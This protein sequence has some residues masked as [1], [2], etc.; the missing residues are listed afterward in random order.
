[1]SQRPRLRFLF[2]AVLLLLVSYPALADVTITGTVLFSSLDG[3]ALDDDHTVNGIFTVNG[4]LTVTGTI[5]CNDV[6]KGSSACPM[7]FVVSGNVTLAPGSQISA[8]NR[9]KDGNGGDISFTVGGN[10][11]IQGTSGA[12]PGA[13]I[14]S[15]KTNGGVVFHAGSI[16]INAGGT[17]TDGAGSIISAASVDGTAGAIS[18]TS[19]AQSSISGNILSGPSRTISTSTIYTGFVMT[20]TGTTVGGNIAIKALTSSEPGVVIN[21][22]AIIASQSG[23]VGTGGTVTIEGC[24][25]Q[26]NGLV[27]SIGRKNPGEHVIVRSGTSITVDGSNLGGAGTHLGRVRADAGSEDASTNTVELYAND[28]IS[29]LGPASSMYAVSSN[30]GAKG[31]GGTINVISKGGTVNATG[32]AFSASGLQKDETGGTINLS[33]KGN[34]TLTGA[35]ITGAGGTSGSNRAGGH[36]NVRSYSGALSWVNGTGDVRPVGSTAGVPTAQQGTISL[37]YCTTLTTTG[38]TF[39]TN[40]SPVGT[41]PTTAQTCSP[42]AP[43]LPA[44][45]TLPVCNTAPVANNDAYTVAEGGTLNV[46]APGVLG[47]DT[48]AEN[49]PLTAVLVTGPAH[50]SSFT[51]NS[52]GSFTYVHDGS[53][54]T[55]DSFT[56]KANDGSLDSNVAT[57]NITITPV[58]DAPVANNDGPYTVAEGGAI[59][60]AAPGV[61]ANDTDPDSPTLTAIL[62]SGPLHAASFGLNANGSW[63]YVHDGSETTSDS[64]TYKANDGS[65]D[66]NVATV[67]IT[68]TPVNDAPVANND[69][70]TVAEGGTLNVAAPGVLGNDTDADSPALT[71]V[72]VTGPAHAS[73]FTLNADGS[74]TYVHDGSETTSDSFTYKA[75]DGSSFSN[76]ATVSITIT[77]V[78]DAP[79]ANN[80]SATVAEG[81]T[82]TVAAPGVLGNDTDPDSPTLT[83]IL[84]S[85]PAHASSFTFNSNGSY[86]YVHDGSETLSDSFTYKAND[87][88]LDSNVATVNITIT[89]VNDAPVANNDSATVA[90]GGT[91]NVAAPGVLGNDT[92]S[93]SPTLTAILVT[94]PAHASSFTLNSNGSYTYVHDGSET[95]SDSFTYKANDGFLDSNV[96]T[97]NITITPVNDAPVANNDAYGVAEGGTL[98]VTAPGVLGNDTDVDSPTLTAV[99]VSSPIHAASFALNADGSF[100]YVHDGSETTTDTF[101]YKA[102]DGSLDSNVATVTIT[103]TAVND[104]P[105]ITAG[106][107]LN[108]TENDPA[109]VVDNTITVSD[110][111]S[112]NLVGATVQI[113]SNYANGQDVLSFATI[114]AISGSFSSAT[115][116]LT[117][118]GTDTVANYQAALRTVKYANTSENPSTAPRT[119]S[120]Q[121][122]DGAGVNNLSNLATSTINV[123]SVNDAPVAA[124][125]A[126]TV[127]EGGTLSIAAPGVLGNDS[128]VDSPSLTAVLV[129][130]P[131]HAASFALNA[132]GSFTYV[133]DGSETT[134]DSFTYKASD[135]SLFSNVATVSITITPVNDA[136]V[137]TAGGTLNYTENDPASVIDN[138]ITIS[139]ADSTTLA[140]ATAQITANYV[141]GQDF[142]AFTNTPNISGSFS[143]ATGTLTLTGTDT[144]ANYQAALRSVTYVNTS[145]APSAAPRTVSWQVN[146]GAGVNNLSNV[147][148]STINVTSVNDAPVLTG[149]TTLA[150]TENQAATAIDTTITVTDADSTNLASATVQITTN[151]VNGQDVLSYANALGITGSFNASTGTLTLSG[152]SSVANYQTALR[153]VKY[154]NTSD[155][156]S[157]S[158]RTVT[159]QVND[160]GAL[161]NLSNIISSTVNVTAV[162]DQPTA[163]AF[164]GLPAQAGIPITYPAGKLGGTDVEAGTTVTIDTAPINLVNVAGVVLNADGSFTFTPTPGSAGGSASFQ[165]RVSDNGNPAPGVNGAYVTVSF[166]V[167]GPAIYFAKSAPVGAGNCTLGNECTVATAVTAIGASTNA[168]IFVSDANTQSVGPITLNSGGSIIGQGVVAASFDAFFGIGT[169]SQGTLAARPLVNQ[170]RPTLATNVTMNTNSQTRGFNLTPPIG[171]GLIATSRTGLVVSDM[172][173][174][175]TT[176]NVAQ[177]CVHFTSSSGTFSFGNITV[178]GTNAGAGINFSGTTSTSTATF[179]NVTTAGGAAVTVATSGSTNFTFGTVTSTTG[180]AVTVT[181]GSGAFTFTKINAGTSVAGPTKGISVNGLTGSFVVNGSGGLCDATHTSGSDCTGGTIQ[182]ASARGAEFINSNNVTLKKMY[183]KSNSTTVA[184]GCVADVS[185]GSNVT[186]NGP[187]FLQTVNGATLDTVFLDGSSQMGLVANGVSALNMSASE[188]RNIGSAFSGQSGLDLQN[189]SGTNVI[190]GC[191]IHD[192]DFGHNVL[193]TNNTGTATVNFTNNTV[194]NVTITTPTSSD[195][196]QLQAYSSANVTATVSN[197]AGTC[198]FN[199]LFSNGIVFGANNASVLNATLSNCGVTKTAGVFLQGSGT[200]NMTGTVSGNTITNKVAS[201]GF[202][203]GSN[204][205]TIGKSSGSSTSTFTGSVTNNTITKAN[206]GGGCTGIVAGAF[207]N[208]TT[209]MT[210]TGNNIQHVDAE[211]INFTAG[212]ASGTSNNVL[213]IQGNTLTN[214]DSSGNYPID[215]TLGTSTGDHP[216]LAANI[217]DMSVGHTVAANRN[218]I[219]NGTFQWVN[220][221]GAP[222]IGPIGNYAP[223]ITGVFKLFNLTGGTDDT[224]AQNWIVASNPG[225]SSDAFNG[226]VAWQSGT[227]CP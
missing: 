72:L 77:P 166:T 11:D 110:A 87:G 189:L 143:S 221:G 161:N 192:N 135:G 81:G 111:D 115:G 60:F 162:N 129:S 17:V 2:F 178:S 84:V 14:S 183:F 20:G 194:D 139:D 82:L 160:G 128:D 112:A 121:V 131:A 50:A 13:L 141:N 34:V 158:P 165:Y 57:V 217:G 45:N 179:G 78:N 213:T 73:S 102:N 140:S 23:D 44:G 205:I 185:A 202:G 71:A 97:V 153:N 55:T 150:Y 47:N 3:S 157:T 65:L 133:H 69:S 35:S 113:T 5:N 88:S 169:P 93:D 39:P 212:Q 137:I 1:M 6:D 67:S 210:I 100:T 30:P 149:G 218:V 36:I 144:V 188:V 123:T 204:A 116:T 66:S 196:F 226:G 117:L 127:A 61:L 170:A 224:A 59:N 201:D 177:A 164:A 8:E 79:V 195:G 95:L 206:C 22:P 46:A 103:I 16:S 172:D 199:K 70:A 49:N 151:Y 104:A 99:L 27:A 118:T 122:N 119:V 138:S 18:I 203:N 200:S 90:E 85:G 215:I 19:G 43:S 52:N 10:M 220:I 197:G 193:I 191:H 109:S 142:L 37:T 63:M 216:C 174:T 83:A 105:V 145:E 187:V 214:P 41:F 86:T 92:D 209:S 108:Y 120:W 147:A 9:D 132:D 171:E 4:N 223:G 75:S 168:N 64:F 15:S 32:L 29:V 156:P 163:F 175:S 184:S 53:E 190:T 225:T 136:P 227:T 24:N 96:A 80:D 40:G 107:T 208:G 152:T 159:F 146:D 38:T 154:S 222:T 54:T 181:T 167:A 126:Y 176:N 182:R 98:S 89:P 198:T 134:S 148:T 219:T 186:C 7:Q 207:G 56:Y 33:A 125:D 51:L 106:G 28:G 48:D 21:A 211:G 91:L 180:Q 25:V 76:V 62:V 114:G 31:G 58:N 124:N 26:I 101:T 12:T 173:I 74:Y 94:G 42:S 155:D 68:V 130:G